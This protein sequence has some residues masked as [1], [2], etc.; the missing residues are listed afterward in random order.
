MSIY[1][2]EWPCCGDVSETNSYEPE[3][4]PFC[5]PLTP[6][7]IA[8]PDLLEALQEMW[9]SACTNASATPSKKAFLKAR[10]AIAKAIGA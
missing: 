8:A 4:C 7:Q 10:A 9:D 1:R 5:A 2:K 3:T 6:V